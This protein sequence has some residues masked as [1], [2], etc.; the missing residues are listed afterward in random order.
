MQLQS[1]FVEEDER[2]KLLVNT[3]SF[4]LSLLHAQ[5]KTIG[6]VDYLLQGTLY[7]DVIESISYKVRTVSQHKALDISEP[8][9][10]HHLLLEVSKVHRTMR[11][12]FR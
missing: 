2:S 5:A 4:H 12:L 3:S 8:T 10:L 7:P 1:F 6:S 9:V 11:L